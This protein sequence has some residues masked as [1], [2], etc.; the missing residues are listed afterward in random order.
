MI[1]FTTDD[2]NGH[3]KL[4]LAGRAPSSLVLYDRFCTKIS[5]LEQL[6]QLSSSYV[7]EID[8]GEI[9]CVICFE[10]LKVGEMRKKLACGHESFHAKCIYDWFEKN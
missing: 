9:E 10:P 6:V 7:E 2:A 5:S 3:I 8:H 1:D 4:I